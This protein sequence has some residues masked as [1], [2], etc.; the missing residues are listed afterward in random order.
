MKTKPNRRMPEPTDR[1]I[2][3]NKSIAKKFGSISQFIP[4]MALVAAGLTW[5]SSPSPAQAQ[6]DSPPPLPS[7]T[8]DSLQVT[9]G[10]SVVF[11]GYAI[12]VQIY[13]WTGTNWLFVAPAARLYADP[14][15][16][17][18]VAIHYAGPTWETKSGS[19]VVGRRAAGCTP[20]STA[21]PWLKLAAVSSSGPGI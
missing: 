4:P 3:M 12:G 18:L 13:T 8:C 17:A 6:V 10:D 16:H 2:M 5:L 1:L 7:P 19:K 15:L 11:H 20:D 21:I 9:N 14:G